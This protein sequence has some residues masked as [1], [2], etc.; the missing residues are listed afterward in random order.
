MHTRNLI[1]ATMMS[2]FGT[3]LGGTIDPSAKDEDHLK[4]AEG[5]KCVVEIMGRCGCGKDHEFHASAVAISPN[6][7]L[8]AAHVVE[9]TSGVYVRIGGK[10]FPASKVII[11]ERFKEENLGIADI[12]LCR[13]DEEFGLDFYPSLYESDDEESKVVSISG[14]G[15]TGNFS[16]GASR[17][18][19]NRRAG[20][21]IVERLE[22]D[23][24][25]CGLSNRKTK[26]EFLIAPGDSGGG[27]FI[28]NKLAGINSFVSAADGKTD[29]DYGDESAHTRV[30]KFVEWIRKNMKD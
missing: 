22:R 16:T 5:F 1:L 17:F 25:I 4:Y 11:N 7:V 14:Y 15:V 9:G 30:S 21:N 18:D 24:M 13:S 6:W 28:E 29:S 12:A 3:C 19:W 26:M 8:T 20:S 2:L 23:V 27:L 10:K